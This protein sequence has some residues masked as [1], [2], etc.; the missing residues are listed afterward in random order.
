MG[1]HLFAKAAITLYG[2]FFFLC[3]IHY[4]IL[5][6]VIIISEGKDSLLA[7]AVGKDKKGKIILLLYFLA[8][9]FSFLNEWIAGFIYILVAIV[10]F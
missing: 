5:Q 9:V 2:I 4:W 7:K 8:T 3:F 1:T 10:W 6:C